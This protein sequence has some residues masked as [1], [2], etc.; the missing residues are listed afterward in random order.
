MDTRT[1]CIVGGGTMGSGIA[2]VM[3]AS[4][5]DVEK[6]ETRDLGRKMGRG[7][8]DYSAAR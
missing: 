7:F 2:Q 1:V 6:V 3:P 5:F 4:G 8:F